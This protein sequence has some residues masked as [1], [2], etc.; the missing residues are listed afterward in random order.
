MAALGMSIS[1]IFAPILPE[2]IE[3]VQEKERIG[4]NSEL[5][6]RASGLYNFSYGV[7]C[8]L[9]PILGGVF[10]DFFGYRTTCDIMAFSCLSFGL[11]Y[12]FINVLPYV[13]SHGW[14]VKKPQKS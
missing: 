13:W 1:F 3:A 2:I 8:M 6:D 10:N 14:L 9:A 11:L 12:F 4:E 7:G 5:N